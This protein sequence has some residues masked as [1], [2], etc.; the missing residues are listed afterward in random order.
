VAC[1][2]CWWLNLCTHS[3]ATGDSSL[4]GCHV[5]SLFEWFPVFLMPM[6]S[7]CPLSDIQSTDAVFYSADEKTLTILC[8]TCSHLLNNTVPYLRRL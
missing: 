4:L 6:L 2:L 5:L 8:N 7:S 1:V 3:D